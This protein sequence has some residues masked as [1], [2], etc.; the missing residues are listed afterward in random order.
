MSNGVRAGRTKLRTRAAQ[1]K[2][3]L[4]DDQWKQ[5]GNDLTPEEWDAML[6]YINTPEANE[7]ALAV[8]LDA[9]DNFEVNGQ[10]ANSPKAIEIFSTIARNAV[11]FI[12]QGRVAQKG[13]RIVEDAPVERAVSFRA[14]EAF[15]A[16]R[17]ASERLDA[18][19]EKFIAA[20]RNKN[21]TPEDI[22]KGR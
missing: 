13:S 7:E 15:E 16:R 8:L 11:D 22:K 20:T 18:A 5:I 19:R 9:G 4:S 14:P 6:Q 3:K 2:L 17:L 21:S 12:N 10:Y 1:K